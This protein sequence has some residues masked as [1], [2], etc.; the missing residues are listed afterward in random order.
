MMKQTRIFVPVFALLLVIGM[1]LPLAEAAKPEPDVDQLCPYV[2]LEDMDSDTPLYSRASDEKIY[3]ASTTKLIT[4]LVV[5][6]HVEA[7]DLSLDTMVKC[8]RHVQDGMTGPAA[9]AMLQ[10]GE[11]ISVRDL[12]YLL[13]LPSHCDAGNALAEAVSGS[14]KKFAKEMNRT[15]QELG[16][17]GSHFTNPHGLHNDD[18][19]TTCQDMYRLAKAAYQY[20]D[21][22]TIIST[23]EYSVPG[24]NKHP[25]PRN[26]HNTN[27]LI[28]SNTYGKKYL[29]KYCTGGKTGSTFQAKYCLVSY[30]EKKGRS[31][32][33]VMMHGDWYYDRDQSKLWMQFIESKRLYQWAFDTFREKTL[34]EE[35]VSWGEAPVVNAME[36]ETLSLTTGGSLTALVEKT[37]DPADLTFTVQLNGKL[38]APIHQGDPV[39]TLLVSRGEELMGSV[40]LTAAEDR[41]PLPRILKHLGVFSHEP[42]SRVPIVPLLFLAGGVVL[43]TAMVLIKRK[44]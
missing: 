4:A 7:G 15:A 5:L 26:I 35:G 22:R 40:P 34:V 16:C 32:C 11:E 43:L 3:P 6:R 18:H 44:K 27:A 37:L 25:E 24:T 41:T 39:G 13:M 10:P 9:R 33:C 36:G 17:T 21:Y 19:Y 28:S 20:E 23:T 42:V 2:L 38:A 1:L 8:S 14:V 31:L 29:Y 12:L 30:A